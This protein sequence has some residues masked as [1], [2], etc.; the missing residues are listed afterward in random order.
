M[1]LCSYAHVCG[2]Q[3]N[4]TTTAAPYNITAATVLASQHTPSERLRNALLD[5]LFATQDMYNDDHTA[6]H[7]RWRNWAVSWL[8]ETVKGSAH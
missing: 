2:C 3:P 4:G 5:V 6:R 7:E 1:S 8:R